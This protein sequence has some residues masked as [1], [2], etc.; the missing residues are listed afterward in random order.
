MGRRRPAGRHGLAHALFTDTQQ[1]VLGLLF[2]QPERSFMQTELIRLAQAG[3]GAVQ[4]EL[5]RLNEAGIVTI[6]AVAG[7][8]YVK[9]NPAT[10]VFEELK[11]IIEK[12]T[13]VAAE[14]SRALARIR[15]RLRFAI[16]FGSVAKSTDAS[17]SDIDVL[18]VSDD[19][20]QED[21]FDALKA[22][23]K[24]L[25][26]RISPTI[27]TAEEF[28]RRRETKNPFLTKVLA[29]K[30]VVLSGSEDAALAP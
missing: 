29:G 5:Q 18:L 17:E 12:T 15:G 26:R 8:K 30:H 2:G 9:A 4:R 23:E 11:G 24:R 27:Y 7:R 21:A 1:R 25:G 16:L 19:L 28:R 6:E 10:P 3:S 14:V 13:G 22:A 20:T